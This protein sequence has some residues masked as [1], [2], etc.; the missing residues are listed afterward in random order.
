MIKEFLSLFGWLFLALIAIHLTCELVEHF[1][2]R[3][4]LRRMLKNVNDRIKA[5]W[6]MAIILILAML[7]GKLGI[8]FLFALASFASLR[9]FLT[10]TSTRHADSWALAAS[11]FVILPIQYIA[12]GMDWYGFFSVFIPVYAFLT[13]PILTALRGEPR[14]FLIR[15]AETQWG[16][17]VA[18]YCI[19][20]LPALLNI[21]IAGFEGK[22]FLLIFFLA[23][24]VQSADTGQYICSNLWRKRVIAPALSPTKTYGGLVGGAGCCICRWLI[25]LLDHP[26]FPLNCRIYGGVDGPMWVAGQSGYVRD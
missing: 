4:A 17:M 6:I 10:L 18:I 7:L 9:E 11:F 21:D 24:V 1:T 22:G 19:S 25:T 14:R 16:L 23:I 2:K 13:L 8:L 20:H 12:I 3:P 5:W 15:I 26:V